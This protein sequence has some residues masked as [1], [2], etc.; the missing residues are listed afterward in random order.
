MGLEA[1]ILMLWPLICQVE[2]N[3]NPAAF[4]VKENAAGIAQIRPIV[5]RD[6]NRIL[7]CPV[8]GVKNR[9][10]VDASKEMFIAYLT[11][12]GK[13]YQNRTKK[14]ATLKVLAQI[15]NG[16]PYGW[17]KKATTKYWKLVR[18]VYK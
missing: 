3:N 16:G 10:E 6:V 15:W 1:T 4:N 9:W 17:R 11:Y 2:S 13:H 12:Y 14:P 5:V 7:N 8:F 18:K